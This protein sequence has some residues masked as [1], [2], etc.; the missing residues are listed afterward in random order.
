MSC[1]GQSGSSN[2]LKKLRPIGNLLP[3]AM[4]IGGCKM[5]IEK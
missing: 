3:I 4:A 5:M 1:R 2:C